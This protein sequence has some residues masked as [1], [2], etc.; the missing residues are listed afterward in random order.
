[1]RGG[2]NY[3]VTHPSLSEGDGKVRGG[4]NSSY[5]LECH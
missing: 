4:D 2:D 3:F 1:M 5:I